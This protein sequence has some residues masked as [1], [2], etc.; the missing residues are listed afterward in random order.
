MKFTTQKVRHNRENGDKPSEP[1]SEQSAH[2]VISWASLPLYCGY[3]LHR[4]MATCEAMKP[5]KMEVVG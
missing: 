5:D 1:R 3:F 2:N 4:R